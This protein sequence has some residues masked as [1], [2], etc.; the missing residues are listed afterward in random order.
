MSRRQWRQFPFDFFFFF[1]FFLFFFLFFLFFFL[2]LLSFFHFFNANEVTT[3][4]T[5]VNFY[6][7]KVPDL[8]YKISYIVKLSFYIFIDRENSIFLLSP[9]PPPPP[10]SL[11]IFY[12]SSFESVNHSL[13]WIYI[14]RLFLDY[15]FYLLPLPSPPPPIYSMTEKRT[16]LR[17]N[18]THVRFIYTNGYVSDISTSYAAFTLRYINSIFLIVVTVTSPTY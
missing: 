8:W 7:N 6:F 18:S 10:P 15:F 9:P 13:T 17:L 1:F 11:L 16:L 5:R 3:M 2:L 12:L 14:Y 4:N